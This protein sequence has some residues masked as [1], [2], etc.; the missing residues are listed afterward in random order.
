MKLNLTLAS[1][2][3]KSLYIDTSLLK[4]QSLYDL[5]IW[6]SRTKC[7]SSSISLQMGHFPSATGVL[8]LVCLPHHFTIEWRYCAFLTRYRYGSVE[9]SNFIVLYILKMGFNSKSC[10]FINQ[11]DSK[12]F[13]TMCLQLLVNVFLSSVIFKSR[14]FTSFNASVA[15]FVNPWLLRFFNSKYTFL[16]NL[17]SDIWWSRFMKHK[18]EMW[19]AVLGGSLPYS[20][21]VIILSVVALTRSTHLAYCKKTI[22]ITPKLGLY[23]QLSL[24][25]IKI[26]LINVSKW[27][28]I[29]SGGSFPIAFILVFKWIWLS[30]LDHIRTD[31]SI[32]AHLDWAI[33]LNW[34]CYPDIYN[35]SLP[36]S[37]L[38][39]NIFLM[40][41]DCQTL[42]L[43]S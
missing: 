37:F 12:L 3:T 29:R 38:Y 11:V 41:L 19:H 7:L 17:S 25:Y 35:L 5:L 21:T 34:W 33:L 26:G 42:Q 40:T 39:W 1:R 27:L 31:T 36:W 32:S 6:H 2:H 28:T 20:P 13:L 8:G 10:R 18:A 14:P 22:S 30:S 23:I 24:L 9:W 4:K 15:Q 16:T 43:W